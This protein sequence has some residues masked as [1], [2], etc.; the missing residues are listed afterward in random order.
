[1]AENALQ[2]AALDYIGRG[3][4]VLPLCYAGSVEDRKKP[5]LASW[6]EYQERIP[7]EAEA[8][9]WWQT[10]T[11]ANVGIVTGSVS[12]LVVVD[13]DGPNC[14]EL[15]KQKGIYLPKTPAVQTG[16]GFHG[17]YAH[18]GNGQ[19]I[20]NRVR[21]LTDGAGSAIDIRGDGGYVA[22]PPSVHGSGRLYQWVIPP[23]DPR[24]PL[25]D[26]IIAL[27]DREQEESS[28]QTAEGWVSTVIDGVSEGNRNDTAARLAGYFLRLNK[29]HEESTYFALCTWNA[30]N[31]PP[32]SDRELR[33]T[34]ASVARKERRRLEQE[35]KNSPGY[36]RLEVLDGAAWAEA[37]KD[38]PP[39]EG[40]SAPLPTLEELGGL[41]AGDVIV[42]PGG[43]GMGKTTHACRIVADVC[44]RRKVPT[45]FFTTEMTRSDVA[46]W[47]A[48]ILEDCS[49]KALPRVIPQRVF[50]QF[51][52]SPIKII[53]AG[54]VR[55]EDIETVVRGSMGT[56]LVIVDH[57]TRIV[58][59]RRESRTLE[60][61]EVCRRLK[62]LAKDCR[63][64]IIELCQL[65]R[66]GNDNTRPA[67]KALRDSGEIEQES[68]AVLF[69]WTTEKNLT[70]C[71]QRM[72]FYL[73]KNRHGAVT[74]V[75][76]NWDKELKKIQLMDQ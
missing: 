19:T 14:A 27:F 44:I 31:K 37:V 8:R 49:V 42:L 70:N 22:A 61:G 4:S 71:H 3:W 59:P 74:E 73:A 13:C 48:S 76:G 57:L 6:S 68:D 5:L 43:A 34:I 17:Y 12:G 24:T 53:D 46:R 11:D 16:K 20:P 65:N 7:T 58:G 60:V 36:T 40:I 25:P 50:D 52:A 23:T 39:R 18:P 33:Q 72:A 62:S 35:V 54:T 10:W 64:T 56:R 21:L 32:L 63:L 1:M 67:L 26:E 69:L 51:R 47:V 45:I 29:C 66:D 55:I 15:F 9:G 28:W 38:T 2:R 30:Q 75:V 41:V